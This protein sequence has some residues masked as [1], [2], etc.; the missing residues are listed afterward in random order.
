MKVK[1]LISE[2]RVTLPEI[3]E[4]LLRIEAT[5]LESGKEMSYELKKSI[6]H[7]NHLAK[8]SSEASKE[9]VSELL[10]LEKMK[11]DIAYRIT[12]LMPVNRD[13]LRAIY[14]KE[15]FTLTTEELDSILDL[16][17]SKR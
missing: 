4:E 2:E 1:A 14:A 12:N 17:S 5:R 6:E 15:R 11:P 10:G 13:E 7:V 9:L 16:V 8:I 3:R